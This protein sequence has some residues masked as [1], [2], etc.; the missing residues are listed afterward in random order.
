MEAKRRRIE[1]GKDRAVEVEGEE[2]DRVELEDGAVAGGMDLGAQL[3]GGKKRSVLDVVAG[4]IL[5]S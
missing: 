4:I 2:D 5:N 3:V 1:K